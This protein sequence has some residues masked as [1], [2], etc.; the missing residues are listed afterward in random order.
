MEVG[1]RFGPTLAAEHLAQEDG[2]AIAAETLR[3]WMLAE[4]L[5][6]RARK[7]QPYLQRRA[8]RAHFGDLVQ[9]DGSFHEWLQKR[10]PRTCL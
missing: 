9:L 4:G 3:R 6:S 7:R 2:L 10:G 8:R 5:G 1:E